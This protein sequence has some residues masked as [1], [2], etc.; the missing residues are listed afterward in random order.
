[1]H[2]PR[3]ITRF[4][5][6]KIHLLI[7]LMLCTAISRGQKPERHVSCGSVPRVDVHYDIGQR[8]HDASHPPTLDLQISISPAQVLDEG[9]LIRLGCQLKVDFPDESAIEALIFDDKESA[10]RLALY[11]TDQRNHGLYIWH[12]RARYQ[13][14]RGEKRQVVE[15]LVPEAEDGLFVVKRYRTWIDF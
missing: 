5:L 9:V 6:S 11:F 2:S 10:Q 1:M 14:N 4:G 13:L 12:L 3:T 7:I 15:F 8:D